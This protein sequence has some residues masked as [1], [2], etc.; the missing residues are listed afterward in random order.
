LIAL[1][2]HPEGVLLPVRA[3]PGA[4]SSGVRGEQGGALKVS[5]TQIAEKGKAN[6]AL[7][8]VLSDALLV[9][10][11]QLELVGGAMSGHKQFLVRGVTVEALRRRIDELVG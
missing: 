8:A 3:Q 10:K 4:K 7:V 2:T 1:Q 5:V 6:K 11:S 9:R